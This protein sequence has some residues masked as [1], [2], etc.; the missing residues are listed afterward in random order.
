MTE[1]PED[2]TRDLERGAEEMEHQLD[3]L[4][5][6]IE[7]AQDRATEQRERTTPKA[8]A[9]DFEDAS[10]GAHEGEDPAGAADAAGP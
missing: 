3:R 4:E 5:G 10:A 2:Q 6:Q 1:V 7:T 9:G 8:V